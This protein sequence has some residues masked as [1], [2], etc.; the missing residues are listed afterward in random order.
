MRPTGS[1]CG[2]TGEGCLLVFTHVFD[3]RF[4]PAAQHAAGWEAYLNRLDAHLGGGYLS[5]EEA[6]EAVPE[7]HERYA[8]AFGADLEVGRHAI[9]A[10]QAP[11][12]ALEEGPTCASSAATTIPSSACGGR[13]PIPRSYVTGSRPAKTCRSPKANRRACGPAPG[14]GTICASS[15]SAVAADCRGA[16]GYHRF[17]SERCRKERKEAGHHR[18]RQ[19]T[20]KQ[21]EDRREFLND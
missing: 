5:E 20:E 6:H 14:M 3:D 7:L 17:T 21:E 18:L 12:V 10:Q 9:L 19:T 1:R 4:G 15:R 8:E 11:P 16:H 2:P 13:S